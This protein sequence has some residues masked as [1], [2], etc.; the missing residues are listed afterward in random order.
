MKKTILLMTGLAFFILNNQAQT[1]SDYDGNVYN[2]VTIGTQVWMGTNLK[3]THYSD[4]TAML[5][6]TTAGDISGNDTSKYYFDYANAPANNLIYGRLYTWAAAMNGA[7]SSNAI[8]SGVQGACPVN[9]HM[10]SDTEWTTVVNYLGGDVIAGGKLKE[11]GTTHWQ[12][13]NA[14][15]TNESG[16]TALPGG[17]RE[18]DGTFYY[19]GYG[20]YWWGSMEIDANNVWSRSLVYNYS[21]IGRCNTNKTSGFYVRCV[22]D[23]PAKVDD[24]NLNKEMKIL[25]NPAI[26]KIY[27]DCAV[28]QEMDVMIYNVVG[29]CVMQEKLTGCE[30]SVDISSLTNGIYIIKL[31]GK[32]LTVQRKLIKE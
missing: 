19:L 14:G 8:P 22:R 5:D 20:S 4:G 16:F 9:W 12:S 2:T 25:P 23:M 1:V 27:I 15:A 24:I 28:K 10:P 21:N 7:A 26:D 30:N 13:P 11:A 29:N 32:N 17:Y 6:G 31:T 18:A 3:T